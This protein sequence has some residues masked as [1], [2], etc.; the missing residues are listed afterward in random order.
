MDISTS[1]LHD[2][3]LIVGMK[4]DSLGIA[5]I[6]FS[7]RRPSPSRLCRAWE[8]IPCEVVYGRVGGWLI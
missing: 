1:L 4:A 3:H 2:E 8:K 6:F 5:A 7:S